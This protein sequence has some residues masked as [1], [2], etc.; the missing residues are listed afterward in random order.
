MIAGTVQAPSYGLDTKA[1]GAKV[2]EQVQEKVEEAARDLLKGSSKPEDL[3]Q[4]G[5]D[6]LKELF[7]R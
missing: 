3:K 6:L 7:R 1:V 2:Q 5:Q 4:K